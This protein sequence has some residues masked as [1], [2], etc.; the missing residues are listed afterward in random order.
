MSVPAASPLLAPSLLIAWLLAAPAANALTLR[1]SDEFSGSSYTE[2]GLTIEA[3]EASRSGVEVTGGLWAL[4][5]CPLPNLDQFDLTTGGLFDL[6]SIDIVHSDFGDPILFEG[7]LADVL[8]AS[9]AVDAFDAGFTSFAGFTGLDRVRITLTGTFTDPAFDD[10][11]YQPVPEPGA[12]LLV[13]LG[14]VGIAWRRRCAALAAARQGAR[15]SHAALP[16]SGGP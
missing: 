9:R 7:F 13:A 11:V 8:V 14:I 6:S 3:T 10:L 1:F 15:M 16:R 2:A 4:P 12:A 5:C